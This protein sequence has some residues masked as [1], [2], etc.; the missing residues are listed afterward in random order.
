MKICIYLVY[1]KKPYL[2]QL[3]YIFYVCS[4]TGYSDRIVCWTQPWIIWNGTH[5]RAIHVSITLYKLV[6]PMLKLNDN[7]TLCWHPFYSSQILLWTWAS[8][9]LYL[10]YNIYCF[11]LVLKI[12]NH[13]NPDDVVIIDITLGKC[14][15]AELTLTVAML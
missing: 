2:S 15:N 8:S 7:L 12:Y 5:V 4:W 10:E 11:M 6:Y 9:S 14:V 3:E 1:N 13:Y